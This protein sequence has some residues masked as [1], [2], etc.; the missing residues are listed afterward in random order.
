MSLLGALKV[1]KRRR[2]CETAPSLYLVWLIYL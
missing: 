2:G 1:E